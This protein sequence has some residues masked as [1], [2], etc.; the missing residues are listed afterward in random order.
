M[1]TFEL[2]VGILSAAVLAMA[3]VWA[4]SLVGAQIRCADTAAAVAR[5]T[6]RGD[7]AA[8]ELAKEEAPEG[9][10]VAVEQDAGAV[11]VTVSVDARAGRLGPIRLSATAT[12]PK[13][14]VG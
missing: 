12:M 3:M 4:I 10:K 8:A 6:A 7:A 9:A 1:V 2:A 11:R 14:P 13:E 5:F